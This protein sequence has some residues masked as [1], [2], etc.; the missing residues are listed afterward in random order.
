M[1]RIIDML[2]TM[3]EHKPHR[4]FKLEV[5]VHELLDGDD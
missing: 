5:I 4:L 1:R 2:Q 3:V